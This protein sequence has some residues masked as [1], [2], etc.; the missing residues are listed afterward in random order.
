MDQN[1]LQELLARI[2]KHPTNVLDR[3]VLAKM[4]HDNM[5]WNEAIQVCQEILHLKPDYLVVEI[6]LGESFLKTGQFSLA[7]DALHVAKELATRQNHMGM[8]PEIEALLE[9]IPDYS[10]Y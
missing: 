8:I 7:R 3:F 4:Y 1:R 5:M 2:E 9:E 10:A 6:M